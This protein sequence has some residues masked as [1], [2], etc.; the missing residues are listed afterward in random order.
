MSIALEKAGFP[1]RNY[2]EPKCKHGHAR[3]AESLANYLRNKIGRPKIS[4]TA[5]D[6]IKG[7]AGKTG[8]VFFKDIMGFREG[9][10]DHIDLWDGST[11]KTGS[12]FDVCKQIWFYELT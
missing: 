7:T 9:R 4:T 11:T 10:G 1:L 3:G 2:T 5:D 6:G 12:Y 8:I